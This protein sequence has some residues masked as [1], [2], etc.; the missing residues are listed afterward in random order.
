MLRGEFGDVEIRDPLTRQ[1]F[2]NRTIPAE[3]LD[4]VGQR[5]AQLFA[6]P[7]RPGDQDNFVGTVPRTDDRNQ[8][9]A[10]LDAHVHARSQ[11]FARFSHSNFDILQGSLFGP[12]GNGHPN[13]AALG[14]TQ[15]LPL[16]NAGVASSFVLG[17]T[18][19]FS[20]RFVN[21][22]R[23]GLSAN[24]VNQRSPMTRSLIEEFGLAGISP[25]PDLTGLPY[26]EIAGFGA[27]GDRQNLP[28]HPTARVI[29]SLR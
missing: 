28:F 4:S 9:D 17:H 24:E 7:N 19:V 25:Q 26:F 22:I 1:P 20:D 13:L 27:L 11:L 8:I 14:E 12:P 23:A 6:A 21:E 15:Q 10:R 16:L 29:Q 5:I 2:P 18:Q 3:R